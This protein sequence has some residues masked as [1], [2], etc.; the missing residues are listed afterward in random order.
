MGA[1]D[2]SS[3]KM[4]LSLFSAGMT[5]VLPNCMHWEELGALSWCCIEGICVM[6]VR[7]DSCC[8]AVCMLTSGQPCFTVS[9]K[10]SILQWYCGETHPVC[11]LSTRWYG[12]RVDGP[13]YYAINL[14]LRL[15]LYHFLHAMSSWRHESIHNNTNNQQTPPPWSWSRSPLKRC[16]FDESTPSKWQAALLMFVPRPLSR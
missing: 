3:K 15:F 4:V 11:R 2:V 9:K 13:K 16:G 1:P 14:I 12:A 8:Q 7:P 5:I 10:S 6:M